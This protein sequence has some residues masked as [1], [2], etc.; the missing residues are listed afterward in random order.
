[1]NRNKDI[2]RRM[3]EYVAVDEPKKKKKKKGKYKQEKGIGFRIFIYSN[4]TK[5]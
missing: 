4:K 5:K 3:D 1:M 2:Q